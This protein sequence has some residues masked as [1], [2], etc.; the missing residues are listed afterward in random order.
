[1]SGE[2]TGGQH[3]AERGGHAPRGLIRLEHG[4]GD[5]SVPGDEVLHLGPQ[6]DIDTARAKR[7]QEATDQ[8]VAHDEPRSTAPLKPVAGVVAPESSL[9]AQGS[10]RI[11]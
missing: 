11:S 4:A 5:G 1:M 7:G 8:R 2:A 3:D 9:R 10:G 6:Q